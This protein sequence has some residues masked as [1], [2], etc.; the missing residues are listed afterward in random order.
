MTLTPRMHQVINGAVS[1]SGNSGPLKNL[2]RSE[3]P[4]I[5]AYLDVQGTVTGTSPSLTVTVYGSVDG[6]RFAQIA[7]FTA[8]TATLTGPQRVVIQNALDPYLEVA[9]S[10]SGTSPVF[11]GVTC[12]L[13]MTSPDA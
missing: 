5:V 3:N 11:N 8:V 4:T 1:A 10:V 9:W 6:V 12:E 13:L 7:T 2:G